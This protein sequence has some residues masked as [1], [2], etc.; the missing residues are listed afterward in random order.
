MMR[1]PGG[2]FTAF[3]KIDPGK[4]Y[5]IQ[6]DIDEFK[7]H[8]TEL[9][10]MLLR[11]DLSFPY[12]VYNR[13]TERVGQRLKLIDGLV[14]AKQDFAKKEYLDTDVAKSTYATNDEELHERWRKRIKFDLLRERLGTK[15][16]PEAEAK[17]KVR[18]RYRGFAKRMKQLDNYDLLE[19]YLSSLAA[20][21]DPHG[22]VHVPQHAG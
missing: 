11:G 14:D 5:F 12:K 16:L 21:L 17:Q 18:E 3:S 20:S 8:E 22:A 15:P 4:L 13:F 19:L 10:D 7:R 2:F 1:F 9:D 6:S